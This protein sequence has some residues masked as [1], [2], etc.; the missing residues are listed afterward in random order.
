MPVQDAGTRT[1]GAEPR[2]ARRIVIMWVI[3]AAIADPL[4]YFLAGPHMPPGDMTSSAAG[5]QFDF[6]VL[7][8]AALPVI[9]GVWIYGAYTLLTWR[10][11]RGGPDPVMT[12]T[13]RSN[14]RIQTAWIG[15]TTIV[16]LSAFVF[17]TVELVVPA[18]AGGGEGPQPIWTPT[19]KTILPVQ[20]IAQ[21]WKFT[22][23]YPTYGGFESDKLVIPDNTTIAFHVT[24][25]D[26]IHDFWAYQLG[27]K[28][29]ANPGTD[30]V[31]FTTTRADGKVTVRCDE[32]CG[33]WH[34]AMYNYGEVVP[35]AQFQQWA[36]STEASLTAATKL[37]PPFAWSY[38]PSANGA[39]G[40]YYPDNVDAFSKT[41]VY[42]AGA[43][44]AKT[45][46]QKSS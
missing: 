30:N 3:A 22:Y 24:S 23:R 12:P 14:I 16:V 8:M 43:V 28:A 4:F 2:H 37:L 39:G 15:T 20:V 40:S 1:S 13:S 29:D 10:A 11:G 41:E 38:T 6:N 27:V 18:G 17:G 5:A 33:I 45:A 21:Q 7:T 31:A 25:L 19:S 36:T 44:S 34:G 42:G 9:I 35:K 46:E 26:V 32:L